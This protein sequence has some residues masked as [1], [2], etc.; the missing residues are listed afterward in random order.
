MARLLVIGTGL[1]G[2][3]FAAAMRRAGSFDAFVG[4]DNDRATLTHAVELG[5]VDSVVDDPCSAAGVATAVLVAV[6]PSAVA[7]MV[8]RVAA[9]AP[10]VPIFDVGSVKGSVVEALRAGGPLPTQFVPCHPMAGTADSGPAAA[11]A[12]LFAGRKV[13]VTPEPETDAGAV[14]KVSDWWRAAGAVV[15][16]TSCAVHDEMVALTSHL[17]HLLAYTFMDWL[18]APHAAAVAEFAGPGLRDFTRIAGS[19]PSLWREIFAANCSALLAELDG[20]SARATHVAELLRAERFDEL[21]ALLARA[22]TAQ[23]ALVDGR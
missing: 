14:A 20:W 6:P 1:I 8:A 7:A 11:D 21:E 9:V 23:R 18:S 19:D 4:Y 12:A 5:L 2:G 16:T 3:S 17:P 13:I 10:R 22:R 15:A